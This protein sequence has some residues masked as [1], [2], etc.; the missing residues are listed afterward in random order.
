MQT[1]EWTYKS[2][3][4]IDMYAKGWQGEDNTP[5]KAVVLLQH[6]LGEH[7]NRY[8]AVAAHF[9]A[10]GIAVLGADRSGHGR[11]G[12][13]RGHIACYEYTML[14]IEQLEKKA[15]ELYPNAPVFLYGHSMGAGIALAFLLKNDFK[16]AKVAA[17]VKTL[18]GKI[19]GVIATSPA[20]RPAFKPSGFDIF[21]GKIMRKIYGGYGQNNG[22][23]ATKICRDPQVVATY[24]ADPLVH[25]RITAETGISLLQWGEELLTQIEQQPTLIAPLL[26]LHGTADGLTDV[27]ASKAFAAKAKGDFQF[28]LYP[29]AFHEL[30]NEPTEKAKMMQE[31][32]DWVLAHLPTTA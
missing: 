31:M 29:D 30:H 9:T 15:A 21:M 17:A 24:K 27:Q 25:D 11:S 20:I 6:G 8:E 10:Q 4:G 19:K 26:M 23:D 14:D 32:S 22:L 5:P 7:I 28:T 12:G 2:L 13:K 1:F 16:N 18:R 3:A